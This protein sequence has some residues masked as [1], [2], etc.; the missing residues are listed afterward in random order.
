MR[1]PQTGDIVDITIKGARVKR[2]GSPGFTI[3]DIDG[4]GHN[5]TLMTALS[6]VSV[7]VVEPAAPA[8]WPPRLGDLWRDRDQELWFAVSVGANIEFVSGL[9][10]ELGTTPPAELNRACGPLTLVRREHTEPAEGSWPPRPGDVWRDSDGDG[11]K[12]VDTPNGVEMTMYEGN[13]PSPA[14]WVQDNYGPLTFVRHEPP[15]ATK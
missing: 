12:A 8:E 5:L 1:D 14:E 4:H 13:T 3:F 2:E 10:G 9:A 15:E 11:W 7:E 6:A